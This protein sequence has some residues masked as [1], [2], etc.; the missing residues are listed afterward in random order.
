[1][2]WAQKVRGAGASTGRAS[3][4][5]FL[6]YSVSGKTWVESLAWAIMGQRRECCHEGGLY[7]EAECPRP[8]PLSKDV[9]AICEHHCEAALLQYEGN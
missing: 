2:Q 1:M 7:S 5:S 6:T 8:C 9:N 3:S 4:R